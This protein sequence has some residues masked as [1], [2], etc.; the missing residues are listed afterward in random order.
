LGRLTERDAGQ[1]QFQ[2]VVDRWTYDN[3]ASVSGNRT[4]RGLLGREVRDLMIGGTNQAPLFQRIYDRRHRYDSD[5][6]TAG[7][8][9]TVNPRQAADPKT[10]L[11]AV[12]QHKKHYDTVS[13][14]D[15]QA[16]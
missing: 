1:G 3:D 9:T 5:L 10:Y 16:K 7:H 4:V 11:E 13:N 8:S 6:R 15:P 2:R 12:S 14:T